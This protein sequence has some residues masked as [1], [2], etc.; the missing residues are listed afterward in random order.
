MDRDLDPVYCTIRDGVE[1][2]L[3]KHRFRLDSESLSYGS[4]A[5]ASIR[6]RRGNTHFRFEW[7]GRDRCAWVV[8]AVLPSP[9]PGEPAFKNM[10]ARRVDPPKYAPPLLTQEQAEARARE[11]TE[12]L[13]GLLKDLKRS[14]SAV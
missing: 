4:F 1:A 10:E 11:L 14:N 8:Y 3:A 7:D 9:T 5:S 2:F 13:A 6:Y 12:Y